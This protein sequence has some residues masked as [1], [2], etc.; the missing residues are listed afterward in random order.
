MTTTEHE[1]ATQEPG[2]DDPCFAHRVF[3]TDKFTALCGKRLLG[4]KAGPEHQKCPECERI[5]E[6]H[7]LREA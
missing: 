1:A 5:V 2:L 4:I 7:G 3:V 6:E